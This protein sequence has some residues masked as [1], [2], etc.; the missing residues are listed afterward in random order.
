MLRESHFTSDWVMPTAAFIRFHSHFW[1]KNMSQYLLTENPKDR[2]CRTTQ[3]WPKAL[4]RFSGVFSFTAFLYSFPSFCLLF[5]NPQHPFGWLHEHNLLKCGKGLMFSLE[6]L[7]FRYLS[8]RSGPGED[9][10]VPLRI[11]ASHI[12][13]HQH[14]SV[15]IFA[16]FTH[17]NPISFANPPEEQSATVE[18]TEVGENDKYVLITWEMSAFLSMAKYNT[19]T[20]HLSPLNFIVKPSSY[21]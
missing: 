8:V 13:N 16:S 3:C 11:D 10:R 15:L 12:V 17:G 4:S 20:L 6:G 21:K 14:Q 7:F 2:F 5:P 19:H 1:Q 18:E 9:A